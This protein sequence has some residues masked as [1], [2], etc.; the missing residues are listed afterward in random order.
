MTTDMA[1]KPT[2]QDWH[3]ED[4]KAAIRK[5][6][7]TLRALA[8]K[9]GYR[10]VDS[11]NQ[12]LFRPYPKAEQI[13]ANTIGVPAEEIWPSRYFDRKFSANGSRVQVKHLGAH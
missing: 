6:G 13:I 8:I 10:S 1:K 4:I 11:I 7:T 9:Y 3:K 12:A 2:P 5:R